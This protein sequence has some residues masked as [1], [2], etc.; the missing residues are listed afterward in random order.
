MFETAGFRRVEYFNLTV[1][2]SRFTAATGWDNLY[3]HPLRIFGQIRILRCALM[4]LE[5]DACSSL[6][7]VIVAATVAF[8][9]VEADAKKFGGGKSVGAQRSAPTQSVGPT[10]TSTP[11]AAPASAARQLRCGC[12]AGA[13]AAAISQA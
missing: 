8:G 2:S 7:T 10:A 1:A 3:F 11:A 13:A 5:E 6:S 4:F 9:A 12:A